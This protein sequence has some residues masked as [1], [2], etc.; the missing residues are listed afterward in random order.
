MPVKG[1][2]WYFDWKKMSGLGCHTLYFVLDRNGAVVA[3]REH[4]AA[5]AG[6]VAFSTLAAAEAFIAASACQGCE[7]VEL[8]MADNE[9]LAALVQ[10]VKPRGIRHL[11]L[12]LDYTR[13]ECVQ[14]DFVGQA[15][16]EGRPHRFSPL[17]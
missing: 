5:W 10:E 9:S 16:G 17:T 4:L 14:F 11:L 3:Y 7:V 1:P 13:G 8:A 12:D 2:A 15:L 6:M